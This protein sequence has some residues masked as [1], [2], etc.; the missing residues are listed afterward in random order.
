VDSKPTGPRFSVLIPAYNREKLV[1]ATIDSVLSQ[2]FPNFELLAVNDGST[3]HTGD[4]LRSYAGRISVLDQARQ[5]PEA[6][7]YHALARARGEYLVL[8]DSDDLLYPN[9]LEVYDRV[10]EQ[11]AEPP[12]L[13]GAMGYFRSGEAIPGNTRDDRRIEYLRFRD[14]LS[15]DIGPGISC[16]NLVLKRSA[17]DER[18]AFRS[19]ATA[20]P[21]DG[22]DIMLLMGTCTPC[23]MLQAPFTVAYRLHETNISRNLRVMMNDAAC[24]AR[25][26]RQYQYA[27]GRRR[28]FDRRAYVGGVSWHYAA[29]AFRQ[30]G[31]GMA[32]RLFMKTADMVVI[33][34]IRKLGTRLRPCRKPEYLAWPTSFPGRRPSPEA[35]LSTP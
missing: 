13:L 26:E 17:V 7:R 29:W 22:N 23:I 27:G 9:A 28:R 6:A 4:V 35:K 33:G 2:T 10:I 31:V 30:G 32:S 34:T 20:F 11:L 18:R 15:K 3:D 12:V 21:Y 25:F 5:G 14:F 16:S 19:R 24:L 8:L 1:R